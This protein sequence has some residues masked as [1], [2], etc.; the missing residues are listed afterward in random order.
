M[1]NGVRSVAARMVSSKLMVMI[2]AA[3]VAQLAHH[4]S[5]AYV[6]PIMLVMAASEA[7][8]LGDGGQGGSRTRRAIRHCDLYVTLCAG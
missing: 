7:L 8:G 1:F 2:K 4:I 3:P 5:I 6:L